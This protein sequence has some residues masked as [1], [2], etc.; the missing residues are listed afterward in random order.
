M[1]KKILHYN[2]KK[3]INNRQI[4]IVFSKNPLV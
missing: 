4:D 1:R 3:F 2:P